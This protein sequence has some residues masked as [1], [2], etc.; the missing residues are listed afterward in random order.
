MKRFFKRELVLV[1]LSWY[2][3]GVLVAFTTTGCCL[4]FHENHRFAFRSCAL[5]AFT[6][7]C[8]ST[9]SVGILLHVKLWSKSHWNIIYYLFFF[10]LSVTYSNNPIAS[11]KEHTSRTL[12]TQCHLS[13][14]IAIVV[15]SSTR[16][17]LQDGWGILIR[18][19][20]WRWSWAR[21]KCIKKR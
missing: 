1:K 12:H 11:T 19:S 5:I 4:C 16:R 8:F 17:G 15:W 13:H 14:K 3:V 20:Q 7:S 9:K 2:F 18:F 6:Q 10:R 21:H